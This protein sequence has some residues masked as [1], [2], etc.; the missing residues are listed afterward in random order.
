MFET[1]TCPPVQ[2]QNTGR[3]CKQRNIGKI[4][5]RKKTK[6]SLVGK[7]WGRTTCS[8]SVFNGN[9][10]Q[11]K[12]WGHNWFE[13][14]AATKRSSKRE[15]RSSGTRCQKRGVVKGSVSGQY[16]EACFGSCCKLTAKTCVARG[17]VGTFNGK[18]KERGRREHFEHWGSWSFVMLGSWVLDRTPS[19]TRT[20][21]P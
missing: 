21:T 2:C 7:W 10:M 16:P 14:V 6:I 11:F 5:P 3:S 18:L 8:K 17:P 4:Q 19:Q 20:P 1:A 9:S 12:S 13:L 15:K